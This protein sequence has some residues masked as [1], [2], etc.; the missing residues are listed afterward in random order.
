M[1]KEKISYIADKT[2]HTYTERERKILS[3]LQERSLDILVA[4]KNIGYEAFVHGSIA[5][6]DITDSSDIDIHIPIQV[7]SYKLDILHEFASI[8]RR[9]VLGTPNSV[10]KAWIERED[11]V[12]LTY[13]LSRTKERE[14]EFYSFSGHLYITDL[15]NKHRVPGINKKLLLIEPTEDGF[16]ESSIVGNPEYAIRTLKISQRIIEERIRVLTR[17]DTIGRTGIVLDYTLSSEENFEQALKY[18]ADRNPLIRRITQ[19]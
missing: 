12:T 9:I 10:I 3:Q 7:P 4:L 6:G 13:P 16:W 8:K 18:I 19:M 15:L 5:R 1:P 17:R 14:S 11:G 2:H